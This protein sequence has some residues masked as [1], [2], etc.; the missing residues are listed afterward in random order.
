MKS[1]LRGKPTSHVEVTNVSSHGFWLFLDDRELFVAFEQFPWFREVSIRELVN[2][3]RPHPHHLYWP[4]LDIDLA[5]ES[6][7]YPEKYPLV[8]RVRPYKRMQPRA[9]GGVPRRT[10][11]ARAADWRGAGSRESLRR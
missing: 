11:G 8:S 2:V 7:E 4:N 10:A 1:A 6:V 3:Q 9:K 5:V